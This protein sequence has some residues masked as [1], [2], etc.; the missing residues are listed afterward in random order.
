LGYLRREFEAPG[1][2]VRIGD[3]AGTVQ[4]LPFSFQLKK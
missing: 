1:T 3:Q 2:A 4:L